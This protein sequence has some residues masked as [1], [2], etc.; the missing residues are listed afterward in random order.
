LS[1]LQAFRWVIRLAVSLVLPVLA[2][3]LIA[4]IGWGAPNF[5]RIFIEPIDILLLLAATIIGFIVLARGCSV[6]LS[7]ALACV[8]FP[9]MYIALL[10]VEAMIGFRLYGTTF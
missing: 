7:V 6:S 10:Y 9:A 8:Y 2:W 3:A 4:L 1:A 5:G